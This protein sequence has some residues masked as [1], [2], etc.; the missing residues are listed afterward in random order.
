MNTTN[1]DEDN[2]DNDM[3]WKVVRSGKSSTPL[4][5]ETQRSHGEP[6][7]SSGDPSK[8]RH[9]SDNADGGF[10]AG[11]TSGAAEVRFLIDPMKCS[12]FNICMILIE[13]I[14]EAQAMD[15]SFHTIPL[16]GK[17]W[18]QASAQ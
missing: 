18:I 6:S 4:R 16:E 11:V 12:S 10:K 3:A 1:N 9:G 15:S 14:T 13:F 2:G 5:K 8:R 17:Q 7:G